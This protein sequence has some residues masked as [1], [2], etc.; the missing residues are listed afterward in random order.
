MCDLISQLKEEEEAEQKPQLDVGVIDGTWRQ[1]EDW[2]WLL[3][4]SSSARPICPSRS[5]LIWPRV[6]YTEQN[7]HSHSIPKW[8]GVQSIIPTTECSAVGG[9]GGW[10]LLPLV[11]CLCQAFLYNVPTS[12]PLT[13]VTVEH[14]GERLV[15]HS[16]WDRGQKNWQGG[17]ERTVSE[18]GK[19]SWEDWD[20]NRTQVKVSL[21]W[22]GLGS[23]HS[24]IIFNMV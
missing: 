15:S 2:V 10:G 18:S 6:V 11:V 23:L 22:W 21:V 14:P 16:C 3:L 9:E 19:K 8:Q 1:A 4:T 7:A 13:L 5:A 24:L 20:R 12:R 17:K